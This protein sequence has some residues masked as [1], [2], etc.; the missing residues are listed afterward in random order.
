MSEGSRALGSPI[1]G[2]KTTSEI[3]AQ[4]SLLAVLV[5]ITFIFTWLR[6]DFADASNVSKIIHSASVSAIMFLGATWVI[7]AG[8]IDVSFM[9]IAALSDMLVA[10]LVHHGVDWLTASC[11]GVA[12]GVCGGLLNGVLVGYLGLPALITTIATGGFAQSMAAA[13]GRGSSMELGDTGFVGGFLAINFGFL[14]A[15]A[16]LAAG[17]YALAWFVQERLVFGHYIYAMEQNRRAVVEAGIPARRILVILF[18]ISGITASIAGVLLTAD[19]ASGQPRIGLS[20]FLD[21]LTA[22]LLGGMVV[23]L[24]QP[25]VLGTL[26]GVLMLAVLVSGTALLGWSDW[27]REVIKGCLLMLGAAIVVRGR[28]SAASDNVSRAL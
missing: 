11:I 16:V 17:L 4:Y 1:R 5:A 21:G 9:S 18:V 23:K 19:L 20:Y 2:R 12:A 15:V 7:A 22:I 28:P 10:G 25:N 3:S 26:L 8:E 6:P 14:P 13:I 27:Q 24:A